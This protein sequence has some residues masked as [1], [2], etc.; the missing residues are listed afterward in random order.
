MEAVP[1]P[2]V[3]KRKLNK[4][5]QCYETQQRSER[6]CCAGCLGPDEE[7]KDEYYCEEQTGKY[8]SGLIKNQRCCRKRLKELTDKVL[9]LQFIPPKVLY[10][11]LEK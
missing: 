9:F 11:R 2:N 3:D 6:K 10:T 1:A 8:Q 5:P 4:E 7:V